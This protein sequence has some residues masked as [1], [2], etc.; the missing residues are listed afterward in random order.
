MLHANQTYDFSLYEAELSPPEVGREDRSAGDSR[1]ENLE[2]I[3]AYLTDD[4]G[5]DFCEEGLAVA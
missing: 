5:D 2:L 4:F 3:G 1:E